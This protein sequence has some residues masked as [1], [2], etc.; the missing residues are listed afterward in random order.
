MGN[1]ELGD[2]MKGTD[3]KINRDEFIDILSDPNDEIKV[4]WNGCNI[5][6]GLLIIQKYIPSK[7][8]EGAGKD[9][10]DLVDAGITKEDSIKLRKLNWMVEN[11]EY[12]ACFT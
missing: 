10:D 6:Q 1:D 11:Y 5:T 9:I 7:G 8:I 3:K 2:K 4:E 12:L